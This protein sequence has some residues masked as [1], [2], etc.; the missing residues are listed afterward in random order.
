MTK[1]L[2]IL[3]VFLLTDYTAAKDYI[4]IK[5]CFD[6]RFLVVEFVIHLL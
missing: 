3:K 6:Y 2:I 1:H 4:L 5:Y